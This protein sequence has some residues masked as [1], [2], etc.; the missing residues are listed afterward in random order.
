[1]SVLADC[2]RSG[3]RGFVTT[4]GLRSFAVSSAPTTQAEVSQRRTDDDAKDADV[5]GYRQ[6][7]STRAKAVLVAG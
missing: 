6:N 7:P 4:I 3:S 2:E 5:M 1:M